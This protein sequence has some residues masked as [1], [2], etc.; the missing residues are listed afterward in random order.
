MYGVCLAVPFY[1]SRTNI[2]DR[3]YPGYRDLTN[4]YTQTIPWEN[5]VDESISVRLVEYDHGTN[6]LYGWFPYGT[7]ISTFVAYTRYTWTNESGSCANNSYLNTPSN[8]VHFILQAP[9]N[10]CDTAHF[11][12]WKILWYENLF[13]ESIKERVIID[14]NFG[15][16]NRVV[17][18][19]IW[20][21]TTG[22]R[23]DA[24]F[25]EIERGER[26]VEDIDILEFDIYFA[27]N[28]FYTN[29]T[30]GGGGGP[31]PPPGG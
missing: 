20:F 30:G 26:C 18:I 28:G 27:D 29:G 17:D 3:Q 21:D 22:T 16:T 5:V 24:G 19:F 7:N 1:V 4:A 2:V 10:T 12:D 23:G 15:A 13:Q 8:Y 14:N 25:F 6:T 9:E 11:L 31:P